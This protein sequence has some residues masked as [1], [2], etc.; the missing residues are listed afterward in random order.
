MSSYQV[1]FRC[2]GPYGVF[3][4]D[5]TVTLGH[6]RRSINEKIG[7]DATVDSFV[8][9]QKIW[10]EENDHLTLERAGF[11]RDSIVICRVKLVTI[12][13][14]PPVAKKGG[15]KKSQKKWVKRYGCGPATK[16]EEQNFAAR[17]TEDSTLFC[18][19]WQ[20][21]FVNNKLLAQEIWEYFPDI[22]NYLELPSDVKDR[23][24]SEIS[25]TCP[26]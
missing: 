1:T 13:T 24:V 10:K 3:S 19:L 12:Q 6:V 5:S 4:F 22:A 7:R 9:D 17:I 2:L 11:Q 15:K 8:K 14:K 26:Q 20:D 23:I 21:L 18:K 16:E 25:K